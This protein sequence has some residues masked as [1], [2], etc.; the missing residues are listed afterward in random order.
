MNVELA[1]IGGIEIAVDIVSSTL[2]ISKWFR[3]S[4][5]DYVKDLEHEVI[6]DVLSKVIDINERLKYLLNGGE[7]IIVN[8]LM[9]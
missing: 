3:N 2:I 7:E 4:F 5:K 8:K 1:R 9:T 6:H